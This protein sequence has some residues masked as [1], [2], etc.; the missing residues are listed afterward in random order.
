MRFVVR[1]Q[2][3]R[4]RF[5]LHLVV[6]RAVVVAVIERLEVERF[7]GLG[8]P[9]PQRVAGGD[10][11]AGDRRVV[12]HAAHFGLRN[13]AHAIAVLLVGERLRA[14]AE[15]H[16]IRDLRARDLPRVAVL[17]PFVGDLGLPAVAD[18][19]IENAELIADAV[20]DRGHFDR[21]ERIHV[22]RREPPES[23]VAK[24]GFL[25]LRNDVVEI[26]AKRAQRFTR[27]FGNAEI[28][29]IVRKVWT[30]QI[31]RGE[32]RDA[33]RV[34]SAVAGDAFD[35]ALKDPVAH[36]QRERDVKIVFRRD[37]FEPAEAVAKILEK[38]LLDFVG[39]ESG[40]DAGA[41]G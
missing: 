3:F 32:I 4:D 15:F 30:G 22:T 39:G 12:G 38:G 1:I 16:L 21:G 26:V 28:E 29:Q 41:G 18:D 37:T 31:F 17:Q 19:L 33:A 2:H 35:T 40:S 24:A 10:A 6:H 34:L 36:S 9:K 8:F 11:V 25:L 5:R 23:A 20:A 27:R 7:D 13:P 14:S